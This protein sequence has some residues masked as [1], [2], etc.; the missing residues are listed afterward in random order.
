[1]ILLVLHYEFIFHSQYIVAMTSQ[2]LTAIQIT[3]NSSVVTDY[4]RKSSNECC[5]CGF[6]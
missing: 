6:I 3:V 1:M 2:L 4:S 5:T